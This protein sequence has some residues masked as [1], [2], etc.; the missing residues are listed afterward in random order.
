MSFS[1]VGEEEE[2][3]CKNNALFEKC[4]RRSARIQVSFHA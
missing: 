3:A 2:E 1:F 4:A